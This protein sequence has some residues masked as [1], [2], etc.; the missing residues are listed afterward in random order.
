MGDFNSRICPRHVNPPYVGPHLFHSTSPDSAYTQNS[1]LMTEFLLTQ[2]M[3][4]PH[5]F[6]PQPKS[7]YITYLE[8]GS[9]P[10]ANSN[11]PTELDFA[12]L[13]HVMVPLYAKSSFK[14]LTSLTQ[15][16]FPTRHFP[17]SIRF[18]SERIPRIIPPSLTKTIFSANETTETR[19]P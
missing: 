4:L 5:T 12:H 1:D 6:V 2:N 7:C 16:S 3:C 18:S 9:S 19:L 10:D 13:D 11:Y 15:E 8:I 14:N 17:L